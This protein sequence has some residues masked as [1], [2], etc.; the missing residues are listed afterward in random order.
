[1][2]LGYRGSRSTVLG[3]AAPNCLY[4][5]EPDRGD[6]PASKPL[7]QRSAFSGA[8]AIDGTGNWLA[9]NQLAAANDAPESAYMG[10]AGAPIPARRVRHHKL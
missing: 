9:L 1:M 8:I 3:R 10:P 5:P 7:S 6:R 4:V 2:R